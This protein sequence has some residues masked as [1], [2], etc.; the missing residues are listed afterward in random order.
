MARQVSVGPVT[1][2]PVSKTGKKCSWGQDA[3]VLP[4][5]TKVLWESMKN[6][7]LLH[8]T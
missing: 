4:V 8:L 5:D 3:Q 2:E 6:S 1:E 7:V